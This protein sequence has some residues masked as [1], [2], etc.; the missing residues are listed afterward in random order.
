VAAGIPDECP[1]C[2]GDVQLAEGFGTTLPYTCVEC[3]NNF[4][5]AVN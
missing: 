1:K 5:E 2:G 3:G 4:S